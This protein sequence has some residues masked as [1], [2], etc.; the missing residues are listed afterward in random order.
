MVPLRVSILKNP[1]ERCNSG[2]PYQ[3][4]AIMALPN[5]LTFFD[6][7]FILI[8]EI[9]DLFFFFCSS[10]PM[11]AIVKWYGSSDTVVLI[12]CRLRSL[13]DFHFFSYLSIGSFLILARLYRDHS[14]DLVHRPGSGGR[15]TW[16]CIFLSLETRSHSYR[17]NTSAGNIWPSNR[18]CRYDNCSCP[19][20]S[21]IAHV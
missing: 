10:R 3:F 19:F 2:V 7:G 6:F 16:V 17:S 21:I 13:L 4:A 5:G 9:E 14:R 15:C 18:S 8:F 12:K 1:H 11:I 20:L